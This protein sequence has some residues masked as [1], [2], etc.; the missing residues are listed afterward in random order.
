MGQTPGGVFS[1]LFSEPSSSSSSSSSVTNSIPDEFKQPP[2]Q[3]FGDYLHNNVAASSPLKRKLSQEEEADQL[4]EDLLAG[5]DSDV[6]ELDVKPVI[7]QEKRSGVQLLIRK[8]LF[9]QDAPNITHQSNVTVKTPQKDVDNN[10][11]QQLHQ[12]QQQQQTAMLSRI[13][14]G[15]NG[16]I[17]QSRALLDSSLNNGNSQ[18]QNEL[19]LS[20]ASYNN[21]NQLG[22]HLI[23]GR[24]GNTTATL[25][26]VL[27]NG[28]SERSKE[29]SILPKTLHQTPTLPP[30]MTYLGEVWMP[31]NQSH[32]NLKSIF[33]N[34]VTAIPQNVTL[35]PDSSIQ[36]PPRVVRRVFD[37]HFQ[38]QSLHPVIQSYQSERVAVSNR[39][40]DENQFSTSG[41]RKR[42]EDNQFSTSGLMPEHAYGHS[43]FPAPE[44]AYATSV[45]SPRVSSELWG[46]RGRYVSRR[47][48]GVPLYDDPTLPPGWTR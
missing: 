18:Q 16:S 28:T 15:V 46:S 42:L 37:Q 5:S 21:I 48:D 26:K 10:Q 35:T 20:R 19:T 47:S 17:L 9:N 27:P 41:V 40:L 14:T 38:S 36:N 33:D 8:D 4:V 12:L 43:M 29:R 23:P 45:M 30:N 13:E 39:M 31:W 32:S 7:V 34:N 22:S 44:H 2:A 1:N 25:T 11:Q 3:Q 24:P 6:E